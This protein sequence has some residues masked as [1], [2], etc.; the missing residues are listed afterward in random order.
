MGNG[1]VSVTVASFAGMPPNSDL[2][3]SPVAATGGDDDDAAAAADPNMEGALR[4]VVVVVVAPN[5]AP[6]NDEPPPPGKVVVAVGGAIIGAI[7][8]VIA[9]VAV[10]LLSTIAV[11]VTC[12]V[13]TEGVAA[14][15]RVGVGDMTLVAAAVGL[16]VPKMLLNAFEEKIFL[17][18]S[19][20]AAAEEVEV[21][22]VVANGE[23]IL[24]V[25]SLALSFINGAM[26]DPNAIFVPPPSLAT[27]AAWPP[28]KEDF[29]G[30]VA[31][32][33][34]GIAVMDTDVGKES[35][36]VVGAVAAAAV[37]IG[38][39]VVVDAI[40]PIAVVLLLFVACC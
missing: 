25:S 26:P 11:V 24:S 17:C 2:M 32:A 40:F 31:V 5:P 10:K 33:T 29:A 7:E 13:L 35:L 6:K 36:A 12:P 8:V 19:A 16:A 9:V 28:K 1:V 20:G 23:Q 34:G 39:I 4:L 14:A 18:T 3:P 30:S 37:L 15:G 22:V 38:V 21:V 27:N